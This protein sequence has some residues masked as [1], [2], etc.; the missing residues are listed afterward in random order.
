MRDDIAKRL[1]ANGI[2]KIPV[3][4]LPSDHINQIPLVVKIEVVVE[5][6]E[7]IN[8]LSLERVL[9]ALDGLLDNHHDYLQMRVRIN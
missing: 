7:Y 8:K 4:M 5:D 1:V 6:K 2:V 9:K 3:H